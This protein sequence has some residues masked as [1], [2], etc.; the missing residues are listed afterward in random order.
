MSA[1]TEWMFAWEAADPDWKPQLPDP[2]ALALGMRVYHLKHE[3]M[4]RDLI[5]T[6]MHYLMVHRS[7][8]SLHH[9]PYGLCW[10][11]FVRA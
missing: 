2:F 4:L 11:I 8:M 5:L 7:G 10:F 1:I 3:T 9:M 6:L